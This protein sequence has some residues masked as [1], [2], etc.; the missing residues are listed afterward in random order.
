MTSF[1]GP[2]GQEDM[3]YLLLTGPVT[4]PRAIKF[5]MLADYSPQDKEFAAMLNAAK[6]EL[7]SLAGANDEFACLLVPG[8]GTQATEAAVGAFCPAKR[9]KTLVISNG[10][11][12]EAAIQMLER[13]GKPC[14]KLIYKETSRITTEDITNALSG[15]RNITHVWVTHCE[16]AS[17]MLNAVEDIVPIVK[18]TGRIMMLDAST[19]FGG[20]AFDLVR[21]GIDVIV[22]KPDACLESVGGIGIVL[23]RKSLFEGEITPSHS[24]SLDLHR[25]FAA[26]D[27]VDT[28]L[29]TH[30][31]IALHDALQALKTEGSVEGRG[32]RYLGNANT[33][34]TRLRGLGCSLFLPDVD[35]SPFV[36]TILAPHAPR[37]SFR[38]LQAGLRQ[39][40]FIIAPGTLSSRASFRVGCIGMV[41]E[42]VMQQFVKAVDEVMKSMEL[43]SLAAEPI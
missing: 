18:S 27:E 21:S 6:Q 24:P 13:L 4:T 15:D 43:Q 33:I 16:T 8:G 14:V 28:Q 34:R 9:K 2:D 42:P 20:M 11:D 39:R 30:S 10:A 41:D 38:A 32:R 26:G 35:A 31:V 12:G 36:Q 17:G 40:G 1:R 5:S 7:L 25:L 3:P 37:F 29:P 19:T 22:T 23:A